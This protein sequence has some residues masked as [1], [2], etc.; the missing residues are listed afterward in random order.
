MQSLPYDK[1]PTC[2]KPPHSISPA[3]LLVLSLLESIELQFLLGN[4]VKA[5]TQ[6]VERISLCRGARLN[7][8]SHALSVQLRRHCFNHLIIG[9]LL[10]TFSGRGSSLPQVL[11]CS[12]LPELVQDFFQRSSVVRWGSVD[13]TPSLTKPPDHEELFKRKMNDG[14]YLRAYSAWIWPKSAP[15]IFFSSKNALWA[16]VHSRTGMPESFPTC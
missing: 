8:S 2:S 15:W 5:G 7:S 10:H 12:F 16:L 4:L 6:N 9:H 3:Q 14:D 13:L 1:P 11:D